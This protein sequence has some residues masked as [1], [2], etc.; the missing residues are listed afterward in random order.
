MLRRDHLVVELLRR[1]RRRIPLVVL[2][3]GG[4]GSNTWRY[5]NRT[6]A[7]LPQQWTNFKIQPFLSAEILYQ[8]VNSSWNQYRLRAGL[9]SRLAEKLQSEA[10]QA[11]TEAIDWDEQAK[12]ARLEADAAAGGVALNGAGAAREVHLSAGAA[13]QQPVEGAGGAQGEV[14]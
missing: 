4:Y 5:R 14:A 8:F 7:I 9:D 6:Q 1:R 12:A 10:E 2:L 3:A 13:R 11:E